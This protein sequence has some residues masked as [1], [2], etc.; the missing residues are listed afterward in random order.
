MRKLLLTLFTFFLIFSC[1]QERNNENDNS[2]FATYGLLTEELYTLNVLLKEQI[3]N[4]LDNGYL[5]DNDLHHI[6]DSLTTEYVA[7]LDITSEALLNKVDVE[8]PTDYSGDFSNPKYINDYFFDG[9]TYNSKAIQFI[10]NTNTY[11]TELLKLVENENLASKIEFILQT[12][13]PEMRNGEKVK[14]LNYYYKDMPLIGVIAYINHKKS[15]ILELELEYLK[16]LKIKPAA[17]N[18]YSK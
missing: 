3:I 4:E 2:D 17:N 8:T 13:D 16:N 11:R 7:L 12:H 9:Q 18:T 10:K 6:Y 14:Y 1:N 5:E 15:S